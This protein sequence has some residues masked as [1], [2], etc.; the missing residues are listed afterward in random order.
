[1]KAGATHIHRAALKV[2][3]QLMTSRNAMVDRLCGMLKLFWLRMGSVTTPSKRRERLAALFT[4]RPDLNAVFHPPI[5]SI[6]ALEAQLA[7][8]SRLLDA[9]APPSQIGS[10]AGRPGP[11]R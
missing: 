4:Q 10:R 2:R 1:M 7:R 6:E 8:S 9:R 3:A 5:E 11:H